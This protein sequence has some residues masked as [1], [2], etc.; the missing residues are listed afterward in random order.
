MNRASGRGIACI[1]DFD[2][3]DPQQGEY[4]TGFVRDRK[5]Y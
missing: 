2:V 5:L 1:H 3:S 4:S